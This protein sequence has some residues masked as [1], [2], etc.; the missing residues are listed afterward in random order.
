M[1]P[2]KMKDEYIIKSIAKEGDYNIY[3]TVAVVEDQNG[4]ETEL[5]MIQRWP[6]KI[7]P[8][9]AYKEKP[10][11][12]RLLETGVRSIDTLNPIVE[13][14]TG[15]IPGGAFGTGKLCFSTPSQ[16]RQRPI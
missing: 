1:V 6:V 7:P 4:N 3:K 15:F 9:T 12:Y 5:N 2:F 11:P 14:G 13:G 10:R 16:N 8:L